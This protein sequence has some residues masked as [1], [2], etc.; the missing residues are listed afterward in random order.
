M[1]DGQQTGASLGGDYRNAVAGQNNLRLDLLALRQICLRA[2]R[3]SAATLK[4]WTQADKTGIPVFSWSWMMLRKQGMSSGPRL[5]TLH[6]PTPIHHSSWERQ[7]GPKGCSLQDLT[8]F[9]HPAVNTGSGSPK[10]SCRCWTLDQPP[11]RSLCPQPLPPELQPP[12][13]SPE[14]PG[15]LLWP[16]TQ[17]PTADSARLRCPPLTSSAA[18]PGPRSPSISGMEPTP[19]SACRAQHAHLLCAAAFH[20]SLLCHPP[21]LC[22]CTMPLAFRFCSKLSDK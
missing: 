12:P 4:P 2:V 1:K 7:Q 20:L 10:P 18:L 19:F 21:A 11:A 13:S 15:N 8:P 3:S 14:R 6:G 16:A 22:I 17:K 5:G 9:H